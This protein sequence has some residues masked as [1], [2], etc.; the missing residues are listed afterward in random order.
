[1]RPFAVFLLIL[2]AVAVIGLLVP[3]RVFAE[4]AKRNPNQPGP[5]R[6]RSRPE[7]GTRMSES[8]R[9]RRGRCLAA[10]GLWANSPPASYWS[11]GAAGWAARAWQSAWA[12]GLWSCQVSPLSVLLTTPPSSMPATTRF[13]SVCEGAMAR[14]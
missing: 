5:R 11:Q 1:M 3:A 13:G 6:I 7:I 12:P 4:A 10:L 8:G 14:T 2:V 9:G